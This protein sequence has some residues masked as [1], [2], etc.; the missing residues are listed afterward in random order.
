VQTLVVA[1]L[2][3]AGD[4]VYYYGHV[5]AQQTNGERGMRFNFWVDASRNAVG[6]GILTT[7]TVGPTG[8]TDV[9]AVPWTTVGVPVGWGI[10]EA[11]LVGN[12]VQV[13]FNGAAGQTV[14]WKLV[15]TRL[16]MNGATP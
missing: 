5:R 15:F 1:N 9:A 7:G 11:N 6:S 8:Y 2:N 12:Q 10:T 13:L 4:G 16:L 3:A 14:Q